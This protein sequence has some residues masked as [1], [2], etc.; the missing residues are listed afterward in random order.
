MKKGKAKAVE[1]FFVSLSW[2]TSQ[3]RRLERRNPFLQC[4]TH[5]TRPK[6]KLLSAFSYSPSGRI[7][8]VWRASIIKTAR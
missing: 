1:S 6:N 4:D 3:R 5:Q 8:A 2:N 7:T